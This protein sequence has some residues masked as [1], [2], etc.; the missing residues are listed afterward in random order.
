ME[1]YIGSYPEIITHGLLQ[2]ARPG[3]LRVLASLQPDSR[4]LE[5]AWGVESSR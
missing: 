4:Q 2:Q 3:R 5:S 1:S